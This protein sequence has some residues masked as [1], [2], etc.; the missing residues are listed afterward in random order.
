VRERERVRLGERERERVRLGE[1][2]R[3]LREN[4]RGAS[5]RT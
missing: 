2:E 5:E 1:R 3:S 4:L